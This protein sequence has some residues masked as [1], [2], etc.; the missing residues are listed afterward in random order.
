MLVDEDGTQF[1]RSFQQF[2]EAMTQTA[3]TSLRSPVRDL[4]EGHVGTECATLPVISDSFPPYDHANVH[5]ALSAYLDENGRSHQLLGLSGQQRHFES[6]ADLVHGARFGVEIG[7]V[8][9]VNLPV[10]PT[11]TLP[12]VQFG[13]FLIDA[14]GARLVVLMRGPT[15]YGPQQAVTLEILSADQEKARAFLAEIRRLMSERNIFRNQMISFGE[16]HM[17]HTGLG[18]VVFLTR[19]ELARDQ[20]ILPDKALDLVE[21]QV[22]GIA[23]HNEPLRASGQQ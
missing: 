15:E 19:P 17:G 18:P 23:G 22:F 8:D 11:A 12:C 4:L 21:R 6:L 13:L 2:M 16:N 1:A 3:R 10:S 14:G 5:V 20:L 9:F 7:S